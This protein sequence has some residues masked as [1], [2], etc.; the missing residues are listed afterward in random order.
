MSA[1]PGFSPATKVLSP[2]EM[3]ALTSASRFL[4]EARKI[5][6]RAQQDVA[7]A[8]EKGRKQGY[9]EGYAE[10][11]RAALADL[12]GAVAEARERL[13][14]SDDELAQIV[15]GA[16]EGMIGTLDAGDLARRCVRRALEEAAEDIWALV[17]VAP[18]ELAMFTADLKAAPVTAAWPE[19]RG[20]EP[21]P[22]LKAGEIILETPKG[23]I[24][25]GLK[26][27]L[28]RLRAGLQGG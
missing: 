5:N 15:I 3:N 23:R 21:D 16:V 20:V 25:V 13:V 2:Q 12:A 27:Q 28:S 24:H 9:E 1:P 4:A 8:V 17:R 14:A 22:L 18:E 7:D 26:Q 6:A 11:R 10:G 19:I